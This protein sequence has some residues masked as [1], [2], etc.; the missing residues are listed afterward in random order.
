M[1]KKTKKL[2]KQLG[3][4]KK[5]KNREAFLEEKAKKFPAKKRDGG[6]K[7]NKHVKHKTDFEISGRKHLKF[8]KVLPLTRDLVFYLGKTVKKLPKTETNEIAG[9]LPLLSVWHDTKYNQLIIRHDGLIRSEAVL[10]QDS[11]GNPIL[12]PDVNYAKARI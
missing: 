10:E 12:V 3:K 9:A 11:S 7:K 4:S 2:M 6:A 1:K 5:Q 8:I